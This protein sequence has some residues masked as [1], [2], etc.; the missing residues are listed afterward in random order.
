[1]IARCL[2]LLAPLVLLLAVAPG[3]SHRITLDRRNFDGKIAVS[4][5]AASTIR[6][7][8]SHRLKVTYTVPRNGAS[9][10]DTDIHLLGRRQL[11]HRLVGRQ[12]RGKLIAIDDLRRSPRV[13]VAFDDR[14]DTRSCAFSFVGSDD[15][16]R[17]SLAS[18]PDLLPATVTV[19]A[20]DRLL[21]RGL[22]RGYVRHL[23]EP[24]QVYR[25][26]RRRGPLTV[27]LEVV[28]HVQPRRIR[29]RVDDGAR[30]ERPNAPP[31]R[32]TTRSSR[33]E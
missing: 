11:L 32:V 5:T 15:G 17:F 25:A 24:A 31:R 7:Y 12:T 27:D 3:C 14:C 10:V 2:R 28:E 30:P 4:D 18:V 1:M 33:E 29:I 16:A 6:V 13:W 20:R 19:A 21:V 26:A 8:L 23:G 22:A 9:F